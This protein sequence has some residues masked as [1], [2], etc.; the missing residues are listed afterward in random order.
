[1]L[2]FGPWIPRAMPGKA[3]PAVLRPVVGEPAL[4]GPG[5]YVFSGSRMLSAAVW[6]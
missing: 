3:G 1:M 2:R 4:S 5:G 6:D